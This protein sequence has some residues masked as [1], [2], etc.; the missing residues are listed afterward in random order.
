MKT[1][2]EDRENVINETLLFL[3]KELPE[4][5]DTFYEAQMNSFFNKKYNEMIND[6][7]L[8]AGYSKRESKLILDGI[9]FNILLR[10]EEQ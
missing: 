2:S 6:M 5:E 3:I 10:R 1:Y 7:A 9:L 4:K 8:Q